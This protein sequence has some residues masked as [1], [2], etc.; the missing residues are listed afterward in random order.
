MS[1][2]PTISGKSLRGHYS[3]VPAN[4]QPSS[5]RFIPVNQRHYSSSDD[6]ESDE[7]QMQESQHT[8]VT[9]QLPTIGRVNPPGEPA[10]QAPVRVRGRVRS[11]GG[12]SETAPRKSNKRTFW[13][14]FRGTRKHY[15]TRAASEEALALFRTGTVCAG[16]DRTIPFECKQCDHIDDT[17][18]YQAAVNPAPLNPVPAPI[19]V[20]PDPVIPAAIPP[21]TNIRVQTLSPGV[22]TITI[23]GMTFTTHGDFNYP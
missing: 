10:T 2:H 11:E 22:L 20:N 7:D 1:Q 4:I 19:P 14:N 23:N 5:T 13:V 18:A 15:Y 12:I 3:R 21:G 6:T 17:P 9:P 16:C 8:S